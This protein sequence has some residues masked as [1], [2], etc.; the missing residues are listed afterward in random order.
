MAV[1]C[2]GICQCLRIS[3]DTG[4]PICCMVVINPKI[5]FAFQ[6]QGH[7]A[8]FRKNSVHLVKRLDKVN[9]VI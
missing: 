2:G 8:M 7:A 5:A 4:K 9:P 3:L 1:S 6:G